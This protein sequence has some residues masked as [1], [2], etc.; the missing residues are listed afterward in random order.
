MAL[1]WCR[2]AILLAMALVPAAFGWW[3]VTKG[4]PAIPRLA[5]LGTGLAITSAVLGW[6]FGIE[7]GL[8]RDL[9]AR[10]RG[11]IGSR[12]VNT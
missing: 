5:T 3:W 6:A 10:V 8:R 12:K 1:R 11:R 9:L 4:M 2:P 7:P